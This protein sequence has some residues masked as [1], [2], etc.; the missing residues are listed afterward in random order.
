M[1]HFDREAAAAHAISLAAAWTEE[2]GPG[3]AIILIDRNGTTHA[4]CGGFADLNTR[5]P[6]APDTA[7]RWASITKQVLAALTL[8][9][10]LPLESRFLFYP[11]YWLGTA[12][13]AVRYARI[14]RRCKKMLDAALKAEDRW[15]YSDLAISA[16]KADEFDALDLYHATTGGE[17][18]LKRKYRDEAIRAKTQTHDGAAPVEAAE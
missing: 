9:A 13:K 2:G 17:A 1:N 16:P 6:I 4:A 10:G 8:R 3:G 11:R 15:T 5:L 7:F 12:V 14:Y 18:A